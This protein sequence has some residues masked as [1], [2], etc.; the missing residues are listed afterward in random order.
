MRAGD[1]SSGEHS[2]LAFLGLVAGQL[3][4]RGGQRVGQGRREP[5]QD[6]GMVGVPSAHPH[7][8]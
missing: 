1:I 3:I 8:Q 5:V 2:V 7:G 4:V 6:S